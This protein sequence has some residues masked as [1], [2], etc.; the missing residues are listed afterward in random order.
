L[1]KGAGGLI[2]IRYQECDAAPNPAVTLVKAT[3][4][5]EHLPADTPLVSAE[6][7]EQ[8]MRVRKRGAQMRRKW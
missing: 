5:R 6:Q 1:S 2:Y 3:Q 7:R 4:V 8:A